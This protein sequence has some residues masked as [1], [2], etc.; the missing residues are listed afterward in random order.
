MSVYTFRLSFSY[1][2]GP[3]AS[4]PLKTTRLVV[5][6]PALSDIDEGEASDR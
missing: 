4:T 3:L 6:P 5:M 1:D 2:S